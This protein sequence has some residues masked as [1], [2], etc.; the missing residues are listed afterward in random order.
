MKGGEMA[1]KQ[2]IA[3][4]IGGGNGIGAATVRLMAGRGWQVIAA[5]I[6]EAAARRVAGETGGAAVALDVTDRPAI[7]DA[8]ARVEREIGP[9]SALVV[10]SGAFQDSFPPQSMPDA[11]W[12]RIMQVNLDGTWQA[13]RI[14]GNRMARRRHGSIVNIASVTGLF[15]SPLLAYGTSKAAVIGLTRNLA[16]EWGRSGVRVNSVS[17]G[18]T[19]VD[20]I[21]KHRADGTRYYGADFGGHAAMGRS[22]EPPEVAEAVE[23]L[24]SERA[25]AITGIDLPVDCGWLTAAPWEM[26]GG[27]RP[28]ASL[29]G[30]G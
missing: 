11:D 7:E 9:V 16:G 3:V 2:R 10:S 6:D 23:F 30:A 24:C 19:L 25:S 8:A 5:D 17:P 1:E 18:V 12:A 29:D 27:P 26:F 22:V 20:R 21:L 28:A 13:N 14:F 15:S 4:V